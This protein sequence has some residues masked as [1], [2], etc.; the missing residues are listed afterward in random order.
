MKRLIYCV[1][2][3]VLL[4]AAEAGARTCTLESRLCAAV[5][6]TGRCVRWDNTFRCFS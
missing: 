4:L 6:S 3:L 5:D 2:P 1:L